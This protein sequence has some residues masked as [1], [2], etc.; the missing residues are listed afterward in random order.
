MSFQLDNDQWKLKGDE[1]IF[2]FGLLYSSK[3]TKNIHFQKEIING[4]L[5]K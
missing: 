4:T 1:W 5:M 2:S 3:C